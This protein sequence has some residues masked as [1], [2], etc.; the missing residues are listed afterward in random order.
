MVKNFDSEGVV[1]GKE[2]KIVFSQSKNIRI[3]KRHRLVFNFP[4]EQSPI[5]QCIPGAYRVL[6]CRKHR[7]FD[8]IRVIVQV[9]YR[10]HTVAVMR[11]P[12]YTEF[13]VPSS[14]RSANANRNS[15]MK[16]QRV[17]MEKQECN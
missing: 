14:S 8:C 6:W 12:R 16:D 9:F 1:E 13:F 4:Q 10:L 15:R 17:E 2:R 3:D 7:T 11:L 5:V